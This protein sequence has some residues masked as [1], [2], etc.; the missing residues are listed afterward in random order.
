M[1]AAEKARRRRIR[2]A[3]ASPPHA[4]RA[5]ATRP[6]KRKGE[7]V[8]AFEPKAT[9]TIAADVAGPYQRGD[10]FRTTRPAIVPGEDGGDG[11]LAHRARNATHC[12]GCARSRPR[13]HERTAGGGPSRLQLRAT[14]GSAASARGPGRRPGPRAGA[15]LVRALA[16]SG[17]AERA[18][19][20]LGSWRP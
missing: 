19:L 3:L 6:T 11:V 18:A 12:R 17:L 4:G 8:V 15:L 20:R 7:R 1:R 13:R 9:L 2:P 14:G 10:R 16:I 5:A